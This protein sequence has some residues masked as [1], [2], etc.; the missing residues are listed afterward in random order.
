M[1][2]DSLQGKDEMLGRSICT[3]LVKLNPEMDQ[4]PRLLWHPIIQKGQR[5]GEALIAAELILKDKVCFEKLKQEELHY[6]G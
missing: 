2:C 1:V 3:P 5:A 4:T 6:V